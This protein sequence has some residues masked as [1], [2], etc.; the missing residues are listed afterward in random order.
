MD[1]VSTTTV[2]LRLLTEAVCRSVE[3]RI[4]TQ[5]N[6]ARSEEE[7]AEAR[8]LRFR[9]RLDRAYWKAVN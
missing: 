8:Q 2:R 1:T 6:Q 5:H 4:L 9:V 7:R 3:M